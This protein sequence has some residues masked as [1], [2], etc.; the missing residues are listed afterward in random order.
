MVRWTVAAAVDGRPEADQTMMD[1]TV[2]APAA[3]RRRRAARDKWWSQVI[4]TNA[5]AGRRPGLTR[6]RRSA[7]TWPVERVLRAGRW[8]PPTRL[9]LLADESLVMSW[10]WSSP[11]DDSLYSS[12]VWILLIF[13]ISLTCE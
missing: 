6:R 9:V 4:N 7:V 8:R 11:G 1:G 5:A 13:V 3:H 10:C 12:D 2:A